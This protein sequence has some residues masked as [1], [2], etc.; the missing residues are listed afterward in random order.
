MFEVN[1]S[2]VDRDMND[3]L[4]ITLTPSS[5]ALVI[6]IEGDLDAASADHVVLTVDS[7]LTNGSSVLLDASGITFLDSAG[8]R[9]LL[10]LRSHAAANGATISIINPSNVAR[11]LIELV[12]L[13]NHLLAE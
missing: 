13:T 5:E 4:T 8:L 11:R 6:S 12:G 9:S 1:S 3:S 10:T 2:R 7:H